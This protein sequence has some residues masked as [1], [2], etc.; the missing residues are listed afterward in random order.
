MALRRRKR[1][2]PRVGSPADLLVVGLGNPGP[3]YVGTRHNVGAE[4]VAQLAERHGEMLK[5]SR[6]AAHLA[7]LRIGAKRMVVAFP[8]TWM[9]RSGESVRVLVRRYGIEDLTQLVVVHDELDLEPGRMKVKFG[10][11]LAGHNG[12]RST[13]DHLKTAEFARIRVGVGRPP[14]RE[15][16]A[17]WVLRRFGRFDR[18]ILDRTI[19]D[20]ADACEAM[21]ASPLDDV[22]NVF[23]RQDG[24]GTR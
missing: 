19:A 10:G 17:N 21:L 12:L 7:E 8:Q 1:D 23:N 4:V 9:N 18:E 14:D 16:T 3:D 5:P 6:Q 15:G 20:A 2:Q 13:R 22:M 24:R 11:G